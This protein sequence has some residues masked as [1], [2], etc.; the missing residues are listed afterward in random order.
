MLS[1]IDWR[2]R[3]LNDDHF[4]L[5][6]ALGLSH[7]IDEVQGRRRPRRA[8]LGGY[9]CAETGAL[10]QETARFQIGDG[11]THSDARDV[12]L[13]AQRLLIR[14][15]C[16]WLI[17]AAENLLPQDDEELAMQR[18][19]RSASKSGGDVAWPNR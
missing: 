3:V 2:R 11:A 6:F 5:R 13:G 14:N 17:Q 16:A 10:L 12:E 7:R 19:S 15:L 18:G 1:D 8:H 9:E 4:S